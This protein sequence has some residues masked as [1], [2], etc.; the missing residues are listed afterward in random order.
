MREDGGPPPPT[1]PSLGGGGTSCVLPLRRYLLSILTAHVRK[2]NPELEVALK[3]V[4]E[5]ISEYSPS[6]I[7]SFMYRLLWM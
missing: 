1:L 5:L 2:T 7:H 3:K 4:W 6:F